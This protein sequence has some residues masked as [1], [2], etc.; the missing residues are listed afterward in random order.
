[1]A[2]RPSQRHTPNW[3]SGISTARETVPSLRPAYT[4]SV[5]RGKNS[6]Q[7][8]RFLNRELRKHQPRDNR[9]QKYRQQHAYA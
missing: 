1:M 7:D 4:T 8:S 9:P 6:A 2:R 5:G 3:E